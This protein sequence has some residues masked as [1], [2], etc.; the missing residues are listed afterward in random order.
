MGAT[1]P[2]GDDPNVI[3]VAKEDVLENCWT[4]PPQL[5][6]SQ[7]DTDSTI[8]S[9]VSGITDGN[10]FSA[11]VTPATQDETAWDTLNERTDALEKAA[12]DIAKMETATKAALEMQ[13][14]DAEEKHKVALAAAEQKQ[15]D[16]L[17][18]SKKKHTALLNDFKMQSEEDTHTIISVNFDK[19][20]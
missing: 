13:R 16:A 10:K 19:L 17:Q 12:E 18:A 14:V 20:L 7:M 5:V 11:T 9:T 15:K 8:L 4:A 6:Y 1:S 2:D 3:A